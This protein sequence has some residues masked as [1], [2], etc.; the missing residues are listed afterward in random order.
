MSNAIS[1]Q[2]LSLAKV[3]TCLFVVQ[4]KLLP[5]GALDDMTDHFM[6]PTTVILWAEYGRICHIS[7]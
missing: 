3:Y 5:V 6:K 4:S 7:F 2:S 1:Q